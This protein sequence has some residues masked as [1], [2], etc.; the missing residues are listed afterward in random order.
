LTASQLILTAE[1]LAVVT[2]ILDLHLP[3]DFA[4]RGFGSRASGRCK[5]WSDLDLA[6]QGPEPLSLSLLAALAEAFDESPL[7]WK[8][9]LVDRNSVD[10]GFAAI[11]D[12]DN[13]VLR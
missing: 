9:D 5:P 13:I 10:D 4:V 3:K 8:V 11:I 2:A 6:I 12:R 1:K 7:P